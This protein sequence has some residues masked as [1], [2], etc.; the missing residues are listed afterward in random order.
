MTDYEVTIGGTTITQIFDVQYN[1]GKSRTLGEATVVCGNNDNN[2]SIESGDEIVIKKNGVVDYS[3]Y[4]TGKPTK[5]GVDNVEM[6]INAND[7]RMELKHQSVNRVFYQEDTGA[8]IR[9]AINQKLEPFSLTSDEYGNYI[10][11][12]G[13]TN[14]WTTNIPKFSVADI[15]SVSLSNVGSNFLFVGWPSGSGSKSVYNLK[16]DNVPDDVI[17]GDGHLDTLFTRLAVNNKGDVFSLEIDLRDNYGNNYIWS[18]ELPETGF[19]EYELKA[20][21]AIGTASIGSNLD[22]NGSLEFR[23][24]IDGNLPDSRAAAIDFASG[25]PYSTTDRET[26]IQPNEVD[27]TGNIV[28]R[29]I[30]LSAFEMVKE[31]AIEDGY[32]SYVDVDDVLHYEQPG[33]RRSLDIDYNN[34]K[35]VDAEFDRDYK[36]VTNKVTVQGAGDI[37]VTVEQTNSVE[38][39]GVS[40]REEPIVDKTLQSEAEAVRR[41]EG[42]L[43]KNAW[44]DSAFT[45]VIANSEYR[46]LTLGDDIYINWPPEDIQGTFQVSNVE[47]DKDGLV[48]VEITKRGTI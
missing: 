16:Y 9:K 36:N 37:R 24:S 39:Y 32:F 25:I 23:F 40:S 10:H 17:P 19:E 34:T 31:F 3:G 14:N 46:K 8:I 18:P 29:R 21:N 30:E 42:Y 12:G 5:A 13:S 48:T 45:F 15:V 22:E 2:R 41:G 1:G 28:T 38:Y 26:D 44:D 35:V 7:K 4:V 11:K 20:E 33:Q 43:A 47:N 27:N 6:E